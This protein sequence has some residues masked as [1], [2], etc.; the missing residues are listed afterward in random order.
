MAREDGPE[1]NYGQFFQILATTP[2]RGGESASRD[3][4]DA[5]AVMP[6]RFARG[7]IPAG[8][9]FGQDPQA[10]GRRKLTWD[11]RAD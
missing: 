10:D 3:Q 6:L 4:R 5:C 11:W 9:I 7:S 2:L 1:S 8:K